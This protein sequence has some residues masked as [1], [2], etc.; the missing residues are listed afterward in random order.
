VRRTGEPQLSIIAVKGFDILDIFEQYYDQ[1]EQLPVRFFELGGDRYLMVMALPD[2]DQSWLRE[3]SRDEALRVI[4]EPTTRRIEQRAIR[5]A[6][7]CTLERIVGVMAQM[8]GQ[9]IEEL[10]GEDSQVEVH[11]PQCGRSYELTRQRLAA[12]AA[13]ED[14]AQDPA[15]DEQPPGVV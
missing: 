9:R 12:E 4:E 13:G 7:S 6:C 2:A 10:F 1:S 5:F 8:F 14:P 3:V 15:G 11:C